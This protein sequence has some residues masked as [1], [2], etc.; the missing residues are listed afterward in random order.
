MIIH[1]LWSVR[2]TVAKGA[3]CPGGTVMRNSA[4]ATRIGSEKGNGSLALSSWQKERKTGRCPEG[5][6]EVP[7]AQASDAPWPQYLDTQL[8]VDLNLGRSIHPTVRIQA[9]RA[10][11]ADLSTKRITR[12]RKSHQM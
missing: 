8:P 6:F 9:P 4:M 2:V 11:G 10:R 12:D 3:D 7:A 5:L 1:A